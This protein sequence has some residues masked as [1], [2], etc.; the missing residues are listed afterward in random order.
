[1]GSARISAKAIIVEAGKL[2]AIRN[3]GKNGETV[4]KLPGGGQKRSE[5]VNR[6]LT[7]EVFEETGAK[8]KVGELV[9][10][11]E[12]ELASPKNGAEGESKVEFVFHCALKNEYRLRV[13]DK[14]D[15]KQVGVDWLDLRK[16]STYDIRPRR[17]K[18]LLDNLVGEEILAA[19]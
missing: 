12:R 10:I 7:R 13:G 11:H 16:L 9:T 15:S 1:M 14:P 17:M 4:F 18:T 8:V 6:A 3:T 19:S 2:L 5:S